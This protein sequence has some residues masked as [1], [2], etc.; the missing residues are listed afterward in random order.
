MSTILFFI[1]GFKLQKAEEAAKQKSRRTLAIINGVVEQ[2]NI[3]SNQ[4]LKDQAAFILG[5]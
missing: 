2:P 3:A 4:L 5:L 1:I